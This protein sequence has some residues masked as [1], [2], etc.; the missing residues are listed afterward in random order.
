MDFLYLLPATKPASLKSL[1]FDG[2]INKT[3]RV[4]WCHINYDGCF[5]SDKAWGFDVEWL[6]STPSLLVEVVSVTNP[7]SSDIDPSQVASLFY[8]S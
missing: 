7:W 3:D 4:E 6:V 2:Y 1:L 8:C 5:C